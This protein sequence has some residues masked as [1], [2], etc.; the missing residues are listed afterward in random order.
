MP[1][2][3]PKR[4]ARELAELYQRLSPKSGSRVGYRPSRGR[5]KPEQ[6][7]NNAKGDN[8]NG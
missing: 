6:T 2:H 3:E 8:S 1:F 4:N 7:S 5:V